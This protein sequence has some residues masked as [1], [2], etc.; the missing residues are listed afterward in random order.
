M[1][2]HHL[3]YFLAIV[4]EGSL[5]AA[6]K[7]LL[8]GQ[9][10]LS[11]QLKTFEEWLGVDLFKR[12][13]KRL[14][15]TPYG[16]FVLKYAREIKN[17]EDEMLVNLQHADD[18]GKKEL[19][20]GAQESVPKTIIADVITKI[21]KIRPIRLKVFEG[22]GEEL[23]ASLTQG[24]IDFFVGNF[25][26]LNQGKEMFYLQ[27]AKEEVSVWASQNFKS[28]KKG[29]PRSMDGKPFIL[30]GLQNPMRHDFEKVMMQKGIGFEV[31]IEAQDTALQ[32][33]LASRGE[34]LL[35]MGEDSVQ[36]WV[37]SGRLVKLGDFPEIHEQ[38]WLGM[39]KRRIDNDYIKSILDEF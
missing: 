10:A 32:K 13:G 4:E 38:Y 39:V 2:L 18:M 7:K 19:V 26:P 35:L 9:P 12:T 11:T 27:L 36:A 1:N 14:H 3:K 33:E 21:K 8:I 6:A 37:K 20:L 31:S 28:L 22:T 17:L 30:P 29:F 15:I 34:G 16:E 25:K 5:S 24:R 23:F